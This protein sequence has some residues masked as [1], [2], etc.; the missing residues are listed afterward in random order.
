MFYQ[1]RE[2]LWVDGY[3]MIGS[4]PELARLQR[5]NEIAQ[6]RDRLLFILS[7]YQ[8]YRDI[9]IIVVFDA[10]FVSGLSKQVNIGQI[11]VVYTQENQTADSYIEKEVGRWISP[12]NRVVVA[13]SDQ[14]EQWLIFQKGALRMSAQELLLEVKQS[15]AQVNQDIQAYYSARMRRRSPWRIDQLKHLDELRL[16]LKKNKNRRSK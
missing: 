7:D 15:Q 11:E 8:K 1:R 2:I 9:K 6:A 4:W 10:Q 5:K 14:A 3:N 13:T 16:S 12:L